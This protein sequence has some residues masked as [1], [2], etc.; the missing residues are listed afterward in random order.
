M[1]WLTSVGSS[2]QSR[3]FEGSATSSDGWEFFGVSITMGTDEL[4]LVDAADAGDELCTVGLLNP[5]ESAILEMD[6]QVNFGTF[7]GTI[8]ESM[9]TMASN[10]TPVMD[11]NRVETL[12]NGGADVL[13]LLAQN[14]DAALSAIEMVNLLREL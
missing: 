12:I 10:E 9:A 2:T 3:S 7:N 14:Q 11:S 4:A 8:I 13:I 6:A 1:P 5:T